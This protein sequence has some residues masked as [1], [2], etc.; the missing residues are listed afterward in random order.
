[1]G[2]VSSL[3]AVLDSELRPAPLHFD[4]GGEC[5]LITATE[6]VPESTNQIARKPT[7]PA[8]TPFVD[9]HT[10]MLPYAN[11]PEHGSTTLDSRSKAGQGARALARC[12]NV[13]GRR[14]CDAH[15]TAYLNHIHVK[16]YRTC[17]G[18]PTW[19][20]ICQSRLIRLNSVTARV[21]TLRSAPQLDAW[22]LGAAGH[23]RIPHMSPRSQGRKTHAHRQHRPLGY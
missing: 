19:V 6:N 14:A 15:S 17:S 1:M 23:A 5:D 9:V 22:G 12:R 10:Q 3:H 11:C 20:Q 18:V 4:A 7:Q 16:T 21:E 8:L 13:C 2:A